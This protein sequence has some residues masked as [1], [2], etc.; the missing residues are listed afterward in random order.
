[1]KASV[2]SWLGLLL[3]LVYA[4]VPLLLETVSRPPESRRLGSAAFGPTLD[5]GRMGEQS[6]PHRW[7]DDCRRCRTVWYRFDRSLPDP[8]RDAQG[9]YLP[10]VGHNAAVYLNGRLLGQGGRFADPVARLGRQPL[11]VSAPSALWRTGNNELYV[12]V[13]ADRPRFGLMPAPAIG[14]ESELLGAWRLRQAFAITVPQVLATAATILALVMGVLAYYRR[15]EPAY[16]TLAVAAIAFAVHTFSVLVVEPPL[17]GPLWDTWFVLGGWL[18]ATSAWWLVERL[19][20]DGRWQAGAVAVLATAALLAALAVWLEP[21]GLAV[22]AA[23]GLALGVLALSGLRLAAAGHRRADGRLLWAGAVLLALTVADLVRLPLLPEALPAMPW[24]M[25]GLLGAAGWLLLLRFVE[26]LN[27]AELLNVDL[28]SL[29]RSRTAELQAQFER[30]R[31]LERRE[32]I[33]T[34]RERLM[35]DMHDGVGG[36]LVSM[37]AMIEADRRRPGELAVV[38]REAL[39][40]MRLMIDSLEPVD[41][42]LNAVLAM[43]RDRLAPRLRA[44]QVDLHWDV[45]LLPAVP[46]LTPARVLHVLRMLQEAVTNALRHGR[47]RTLWIKAVADTA[48]VHI[49]VRDDG[50]GFDPQAAS[51]GRGLKNLRRRADELGARLL[52][53]STPGRGTTIALL[54]P[55]A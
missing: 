38:V 52:I 35:R 18:V 31:E 29:V 25:A 46:G 50:S 53:D 19:A 8:P 49:E 17:D 2:S 36:H 16:A 34:E 4:L 23:I 47:A 44:A 30:V 45:E 26:T 13:K 41:D 48:G 3:A 12:L 54:L 33:A 15:G 20:G 27:A 1:M 40:D 5:S 28:E 21:T 22:D 39:D 7:R 32:A 42:D 9:I 37:L 55:A 14:P 43:F 10:V 6:L 24:A 11:W 51:V